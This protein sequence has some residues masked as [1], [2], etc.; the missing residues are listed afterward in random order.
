MKTCHCHSI[1]LASL[2][3]GNPECDV[4]AGN[5]KW[6]WQSW[7]LKPTNLYLRACACV[8]IALSAAALCNTFA[9][10]HFPV[11]WKQSQCWFSPK[12]SIWKCNCLEL[13]GGSERPD[14]AVNNFL[15][16]THRAL[17]STAFSLLDDFSWK[18]V[19][20]FLAVVFFML[21]FFLSETDSHFAL[22]LALAKWC[23][24]G[25]QGS[26]PFTVKFLC[27]F[28]AQ[29]YIRTDVPLPGNLALLL[30][31]DMLVCCLSQLY[32]WAI[33]MLWLWLLSTN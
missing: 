28:I 20:F 31:S 29:D 33:T 1:W 19:R 23:D 13:H 32:Q 21:C 17:L 18:E 27:V 4:R 9:G 3:T 22:S 5:V 24:Y 16:Q 7:V 15:S 30:P 6:A 10:L 14:L 11:D 26:S 8:H 25:G 12:R 2:V